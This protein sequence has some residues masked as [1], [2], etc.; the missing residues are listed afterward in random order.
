MCDV[1]RFHKAEWYEV[2]HEDICCPKT[3]VTRVK[4]AGTVLVLR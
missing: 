2:L 1:R 3:G 4:D